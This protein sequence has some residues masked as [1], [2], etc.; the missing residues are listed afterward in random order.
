MADAYKI[1]HLTLSSKNDTTTIQTWLDA[2]YPLV[3]S[4]IFV[5]GLDIYILY[6]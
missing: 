3:V 6:T 1:A 5:N 2:N 4:Q